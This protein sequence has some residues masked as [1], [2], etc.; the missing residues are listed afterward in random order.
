M[1]AP[2]LFL[3]R[4]N[5]HRG[6]PHRPDD[7]TKDLGDPEFRRAYDSKSVSIAAVDAAINAEALALGQEVSGDDRSSS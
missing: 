5:Q 7:L 6:S 3:G 1:A 4:H 2:V